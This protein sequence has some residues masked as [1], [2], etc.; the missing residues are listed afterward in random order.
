MKILV[1]G[2]GVIGVTT[3]Y[4]LA[5]DGHEVAVVDRQSE[6]ASE[7]S[8]ANAGLIAPAHAYAWASPTAPKILLKSLLDPDQALR[9]RP[10][11]DPR[12]W[13]WLLL[14]LREC[15]A[16]RARINTIR[17]LRLCLYSLEAMHEV[18][19]DTGVHYDGR[20]G[21]NLYLYRTQASFDAGVAHTSIL[22]ENGLELEFIDR[23]RVTT[24]EPALAPAKHK[25]AGA[26]FS[27][28]DESGDACLF[29]RALA[30]VCRKRLGVSFAF[31][32]VIQALDV[33][34]DTIAR[35]TTD[36]GDLKADIYILS[37]GC[38]STFLARQV[39]IRLPIYPIKGYS[40]TMPAG[41]PG[42][43]PSIGGVDE[44]NLVAY[45]R[46]GD[47]LRVTATAEFSGY[48]RGHKPEDFR[49]MLSVARELF[50][51]GGDY[52][53]PTYW[54]CLRPMTPEG[55]PFLGKAR[56]RNL[57]LNTG[58]G[59]IGWTMA[60][61]SARVT[62]DLIAGRAPDIDLKGMTLSP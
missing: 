39:G 54:A 55:T 51:E 2:S 31:E 12:M 47:R 21:G 40:V 50:P 27:P 32:T 33:D 45:V 53:N 5:R 62:A 48:Y 29:T 11:A 6:P 35:V 38:D 58:H 4:Y 34:G 26:V 61:G 52:E 20:T 44:N 36:K 16:A 56:Y 41:K 9:F 46:M 18:V 25:I 30:D 17:K 15:T 13:S 3:A 10:R 24:L 59:H 22:R 23:D 19:D 7:I 8:F 42:K 43:T 49:F 57:F 60:C 37:L 28:T 1:L 14:F